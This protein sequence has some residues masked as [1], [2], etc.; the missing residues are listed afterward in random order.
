MTAGPESAKPRS[1]RERE[2]PPRLRRRWALDARAE[3]RLLPHP[4]DVP[5][6]VL[7]AG[8]AVRS[9]VGAAEEAEPA[10]EEVGLP[11]GDAR[12]L[13]PAAHEVRDAGDV[14]HPAAA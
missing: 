11:A 4:L 14:A 13:A 9:P 12:L 6:A 10:A 8:E 5:G 3:A 1:A 7:A 2:R